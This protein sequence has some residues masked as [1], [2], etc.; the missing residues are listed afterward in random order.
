LSAL[1]D[2][3]LIGL[4]SLSHWLIGFVSLVSLSH[5]L[6]CHCL[7]AVVNTAISIH[8]L[9]KQ[10][11]VLEAA[12]VLSRT[13]KITNVAI[14][15][16]CIA[17]KKKICWWIASFGKSYHGDMSNKGINWQWSF[18]AKNI[19]SQAFA[20]NDKILRHEGV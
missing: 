13:N 7:V 10:A 20:K 6:F 14:Y 12:M 4:V 11:A 8:W 1:L 17:S 16:Y 18:Y 9:F 2:H 19:F 5:W 3:W 15:C